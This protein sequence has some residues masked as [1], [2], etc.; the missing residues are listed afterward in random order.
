MQSGRHAAR[1]FLG[2]AMAVDDVLDRGRDA[3]GRR[4]WGD[5]FSLWGSCS[6]AESSD[7]LV[8]MR[9]DAAYIA[10]HIAKHHPERV[11]GGLRPMSTR[12]GP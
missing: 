6:S 8:G 11:D 5:S 2:V 4:S 1:A 9:R 7:V 3:Y 10:S 12:T